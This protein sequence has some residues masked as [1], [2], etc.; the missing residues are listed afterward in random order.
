M[1]QL[2]ATISQLCLAVAVPYFLLCT[3][4]GVKVVRRQS[5]SLRAQEAAGEEGP[6]PAPTGYDV[7]FLVPCLNEELVI[8]ATVH[9]LLG[10]GER[11]VIVI[12]DG[13]DDGTSTAARK[14]ATEVGAPHRLH[15]VSR[16]LPDAR[17]GKGAALNA[18]L[19]C[20]LDD[21]GKRHLAPERVIVCVMDAD[22]RLSPG[23]VEA[24]LVPFADDRIG[25]VQL[26]V[27]IRNRNRLIGQ[28]Q[29][30]EFWVISALSQ[31]ARTLTG[32]VSLGGNGQF[33][34]LTALQS[35]DGEPW[36][37]SLTED[38]D[39]GVRLVAAGWR[40]T[41]T[42]GGYVDQQGVES[43]RRLLRQRVR[44]YQGHMTCIKRLPELWRSDR[45]SELTLLEV[46]SYLLVPWVIVLP[47][48]VLQ[49]WVLWQL[50]TGSGRGVLAQGLGSPVARI[51]YGVLWYT[52]S[53]LPNIVI[54]LTYARRTR[55]VSKPRAFALGHLMIAWNY[56]GYLAAWRAAFRM[57]RGQGGW[58]KTARTSEAAPALGGQ[59]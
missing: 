16:R 1:S 14:A 55:A 54:G 29:D 34:R 56:I 10:E 4:L 9:R 19:R 33:A 7:Y 17:K 52:L 26:T 37:E 2:F 39:F 51:G 23:A 38:L 5:G 12:D 59:P 31:F 50:V 32:S 40:L 25:G 45:M 58:D 15:V 47:W 35:L 27:R 36:T 8:G 24:A 41:T 6:P 48:S 42:A 13:S 18:G 44:W 21:V 28:F 11:R 49:Q 53:F 22:G 43:Y 57:L 3:V 20:L 30:V 46:S